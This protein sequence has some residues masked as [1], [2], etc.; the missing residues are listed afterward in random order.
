MLAVL[1]VGAALAMQDASLRTADGLQLHARVEQPSDPKSGVVLV[2]MLGRQASDLDF[3]AERLGKSGIVSIAPDLR[4][5]GTSAKAGE[6]LTDDD[7]KAM[8]YDVRAAVGYLRDAG[9]EQIS[10]VGGSIGANLCLNVAAEDK[11]MVNVVMLSPGLN[12]KGVTTPQSLKE[13]G[14]RPLL[15]VASEDDVGSARAATLLHERALGQVHLEMYTEAGHG[16]KMLNREAGL[17]GMIQS[18]LLGTFE[19]GSGE[20]VV[21]RPAMDVDAN[22][23][24]TEGKKLQSHE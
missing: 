22:S 15:I 3:L 1:L 9:V 24:A 5:H 23:M 10:C 12:Y 7:Y 8:V 13:Y 21:P 2:H 20:V 14:N 16:T 19:L 11:A 6:A 18:W 4:G 17:D